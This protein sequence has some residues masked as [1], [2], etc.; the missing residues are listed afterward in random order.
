MDLVPAVGNVRSPA[1]R[2]ETTVVRVF[3]RFSLSLPPVKGSIGMV[4]GPHVP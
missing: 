3:R 4:E 2:R 1:G